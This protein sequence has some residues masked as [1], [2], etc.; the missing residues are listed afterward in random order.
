MKQTTE[1]EFT[2]TKWNSQQSR[3][4]YATSKKKDQNGQFKIIGQNG[5]VIDS[6]LCLRP[7]QF[8]INTIQ[9]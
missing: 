4:R 5:P 8:D 9:K 1:I 2:A 6:P 7:V 3:P